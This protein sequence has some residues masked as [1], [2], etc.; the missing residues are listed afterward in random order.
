MRQLFIFAIALM[1]WSSAAAVCDAVIYSPHHAYVGLDFD[2]QI[3]QPAIGSRPSGDLW[4]VAAEYNYIRH[5]D[6]YIG[7]EVTWVTGDLTNGLKYDNRDF[8]IQGKWGFTW[9]YSLLCFKGYFIPLIG[10]GYRGLR[11]EIGTV[12]T[13]T[14]SYDRWYVPLGFRSSLL[15]CFG[16][17]VGLNFTFRWDVDTSRHINADNVRAELHR[18]YG[19][20]VQLPV[21][22]H[23]CPRRRCGGELRVVPY[24][25]W[26]RFG[27]TVIAPSDAEFDQKDWGVFLQVGY[28]M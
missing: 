2:W 6:W 17:E 28:R 25:K 14:Y 21:T 8:D 18:Q 3:H 1:G 9:F 23:L 10:I 7:G 15:F 24:W 26:D 13:V 22:W 4:G 11:E 27:D 12:T 16:W 19:Y 20:Y 5:C